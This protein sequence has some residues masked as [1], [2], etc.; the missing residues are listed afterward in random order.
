MDAAI[1]LA[2]VDKEFEPTIANL[3]KQ[4]GSS[5]NIDLREVILLDSQSTM[6]LFCNA[7]L[8]SKTPKPPQA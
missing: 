6:D 7:A 8:V 3:F 1:Q 5:V 4:A 2:Q